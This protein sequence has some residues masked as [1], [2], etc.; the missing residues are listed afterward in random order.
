M[1]GSLDRVYEKGIKIVYSTARVKQQALLD[2]LALLRSERDGA[3]VIRA[4]EGNV[5]LKFVRVAGSKD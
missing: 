4:P 2:E 5:I 1:I 3:I